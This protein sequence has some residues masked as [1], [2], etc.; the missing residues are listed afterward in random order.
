MY[1]TVV[2]STLRYGS[3][4]WTT[5]CPRLKILKQFHMCCL[6]KICGVTWKDKLPNTK[7]LRHCNVTSVESVIVVS[8]LGWP[9][10]VARAQGSPLWTAGRV[11]LVR[12]WSERCKGVLKR[13]T[14]GVQHWP[15]NMDGRGCEPVKIALGLPRWYSPL[16]GQ[17]HSPPDC[18]TWS[19]IG[20]SNQPIA[21]II[22]THSMS[23]LTVPS[24][25]RR[26]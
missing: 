15:S 17:P 5:Y 24:L 6:R 4:T 2:L 1:R 8:Q 19:T 18:P 10:H 26:A 11:S 3:K 14:E 16:R 21:N 12:G 7:I 22:L 23:C 25:V 13:S 9:G 20:C